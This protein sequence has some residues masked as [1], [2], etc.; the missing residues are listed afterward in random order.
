MSSE[1][2][3]RLHNAE[4][5]VQDYG[6]LLG[7]ITLG[8]YAHP[9]SLLPHTKDQIKDSI[10]L[11]LREIGHENTDIKNSLVEAYV[12]LAKF[13]SEEDAA[14]LEKG[15]EALSRGEADCS[16]IEEAGN[17]TKIINNIK[18]EMENLTEDLKI[19]LN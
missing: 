14:L 11:L 15:R 7:T 1:Q 17:A 2:I 9:G 6:R 12:L 10:Q 8:A 16:F 5:I 3:T 4:Q 19:F 18:L 13:I